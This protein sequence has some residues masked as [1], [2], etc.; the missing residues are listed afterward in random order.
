MNPYLD[1]E[2]ERDEFDLWVRAAWNECGENEPCYEWVWQRIIQK[3]ES[4]ES[5]ICPPDYANRLRGYIH[6]AICATIKA[7][8]RSTSA[9]NTQ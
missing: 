1:L 2:F 7:I 3:I 5:E 8:R 6:L 4:T 9:R